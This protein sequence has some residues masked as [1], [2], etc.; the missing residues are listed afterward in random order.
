MENTQKA[1]IKKACTAIAISTLLACLPVAFFVSWSMW[2]LTS[3]SCWVLTC[4]LLR[5]F[6]NSFLQALDALQ[7]GLL[8]FKDGDFS[9]QLA[10]QSK[11][12]FGDLCHLY[13]ETAKQLRN[14]KQWLYQ[15]EMMLD[16]MLQS[17]PQAL[18]LVDENGT[19]VFANP[20]AQKLLASSA[21]LEGQSIKSLCPETPRE[22]IH[23]I[24]QG[25]DGLVS[26]TPSS[27]EEQRWHSTV[28]KLL[29]NN[30]PHNLFI[31]KQLTKEL[32]RQEVAVWKKVI[33]VISHE[34][35]NSLGPISSMLH[36]GK[37]IA[38]KLDE[39]RLNRVFSTIDERIEHLCEFIQGYGTFAKL[40]APQ[41]KP[42][43]LAPLLD[44]LKMQWP[45]TV[46]CDVEVISADKGQLEQ[47]L[48]NLLK[49]AYESGTETDAIALSIY[50]INEG[51]KI[52][53]SDRG[54]GMSEAVLTNALLPF[55][56][57]KS[58]GT[59]LGL[60]LCR[61]ITDAHN[62]QISIRNRAR[63]GLSVEL[64]LPN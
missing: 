20:S 44:A 32:N 23:A 18:I 41:I 64:I 61:E 54:P 34:L 13:N 10:Y 46:S 60:P 27:G 8:N 31:F 2:F 19:V 28:G 62:G 25:T 16:K 30:Q 53:V 56:S 29:L 4:V 5:L 57:T 40:P 6:F 36:S 55:Y 33:R 58:S 35:N 42:I 15:R 45:C 38:N 12:S 7:I 39:A 9:N 22:I 14:E 1:L 51:V 59:G 24:E 11:D 43:V 50:S 52:T 3:V 21:A 63:G 17:A 48:I 37:I 49:N 26:V 47:L